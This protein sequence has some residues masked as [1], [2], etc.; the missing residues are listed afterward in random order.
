MDEAT[1]FAVGG[2]TALAIWES[3]KPN[4]ALAEQVPPDDKRLRTVDVT[5]PSPEGNG[6]IRG[7]YVRPADAHEKLPG[8][9]VIHENR[10]LHRWI[11]A[12]RVDGR[13][14]RK[15]LRRIAL[16]ILRTST[17]AQITVSTMT[18]HCV[19]TK[20][21]QSWPGSARSIF[22]IST[23]G[24]VASP[25]QPERRPPWFNGNLSRSGAQ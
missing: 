17:R 5:V 22:S 15:P 7:Y 3:L 2:L 13:R 9:L 6:S 18:Q 8:L 16:P 23:F 12:S 11:R 25:R 19:M 4:Y 21:R 14:T 1:K 20:P 24:R 10:G